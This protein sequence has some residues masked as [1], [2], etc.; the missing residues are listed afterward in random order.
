[1]PTVAADT[2]VLVRFLVRQPPDQ[3][4]RARALMEK[5]SGGQLE[6]RM[7]AVVVGEVASPK[8][9]T[10]GPLILVQAALRVGGIGRPSSVTDP[11]SSAWAGNVMLWSGPALTRGAWL[12]VT[13]IVI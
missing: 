2:N 6:V 3:Y 11:F 4:T 12:P 1:M 13:V 9:T 8:V 7:S 10:P 5:V